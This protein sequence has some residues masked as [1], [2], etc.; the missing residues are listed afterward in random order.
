MYSFKSRIRYS[1]V[2]QNTFLTLDKLI[3]YFQDCCIFHSE[4]VGLGLENL[5]GQ[6]QCWM[7]TGW[8]IVIERMPKLMEEVR[9]CTWP[10]SFRGCNGGR[11]F[12]MEDEA[13]N[14]I[15]RAD[16]GWVF[17]DLNTGRPA[18]IPEDQLAGY[19]L[20]DKMEFAGAAGRLRV[21]ADS[22]ERSSFPVRED[23]LDTNHHVNNG[24]YVK[25]ALAQLPG[26]IEIH[27]MRAEY[28]RQAKLGDE[29][30]P[31]VKEQ[32]EGW[33]V[34]LCSK[35]GKPYAIVELQ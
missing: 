8:Q 18:V 9:V 31:K 29:I 16:S 23:H 1:E 4:S 10:Y 28:K 25:M 20:E 13:G 34:A 22:E 30:V 17:I 7:L 14:A 33:T 5:A 26:G 11:N 27:R 19:E 6:G 32:D 35:E 12:R 24:Q 21:P 3:H 15:A 2:D